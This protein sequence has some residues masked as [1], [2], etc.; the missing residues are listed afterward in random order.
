MTNCP[1]IETKQ[2]LE[3][4]L[5][6]IHLDSFNHRCE[7]LTLEADGT[8]ANGVV[9]KKSGVFSDK[10]E[11]WFDIILQRMASGNEVPIFMQ[12]M[13]IDKDDITKPNQYVYDLTENRVYVSGFGAD[14]ECLA[15]FR[16]EHA[17]KWSMIEFKESI[18]STEEENV[19]PVHDWSGKVK[20]FKRGIF[21]SSINVSMKLESPFKSSNVMLMTSKY[22]MVVDEPIADS[23]W[24]VDGI[25][26]AAFGIAKVV[27]SRPVVDTGVIQLSYDGLDGSFVAEK[28]GIDGV[29]KFTVETALGET[30]LF[31][32]VETTGDGPWTIVPPELSE[33][34]YRCKYS[35]RTIEML[36]RKD[37]YSPDGTTVE[38][39]TMFQKSYVMNVSMS[40]PDTD[41]ATASISIGN[42]GFAVS[43]DTPEES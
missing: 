4:S 33:V 26:T 32:G 29:G 1:N 43:V 28:A 14:D 6:L 36:A 37:Y 31:L 9:L 8:N 20:H 35:P 15:T 3:T 23:D 7:E 42:T 25:P 19:R 34:T 5:H 27:L 21:N 18:D 16:D 40:Y 39:T 41:D 38:F 11:N 22:A 24:E 17:G 12:H 10:P 2:G 13:G 30:T